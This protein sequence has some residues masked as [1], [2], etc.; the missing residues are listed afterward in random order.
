MMKMHGGAMGDNI[1]QG[2]GAIDV[3]LPYRGWQWQK[4]EKAQRVKFVV[5]G[6]SIIFCVRVSDV[7]CVLKHSLYSVSYRTIS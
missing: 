4:G 3:H 1:L 6:N 5:T 2:S 7:V